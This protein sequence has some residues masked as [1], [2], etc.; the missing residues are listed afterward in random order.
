MNET[1]ETIAPAD[2]AVGDE[3]SYRDYGSYRRADR[4]L[5]GTVVAINKVSRD[6]YKDP[7]IVDVRLASGRVVSPE[8]LPQGAVRKF[9]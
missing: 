5:R 4:F 3:I 7:M 6:G 2:I 8:F 9:V 1:F